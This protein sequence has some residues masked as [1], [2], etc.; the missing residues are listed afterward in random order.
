MPDAALQAG[1]S[2]CILDKK[3]T[4]ET[5]VSGLAAGHVTLFPNQRSEQEQQRRHLNA[6]LTHLNAILLA[7]RVQDQLE[8]RLLTWHQKRF[9]R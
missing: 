4:Q 7:E 2:G 9:A 1:K 3:V 8:M 6:M 5:P